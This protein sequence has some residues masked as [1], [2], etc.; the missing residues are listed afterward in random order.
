MGQIRVFLDGDRNDKYARA[1]AVVDLLVRETPGDPVD[2]ID[3]GLLPYTYTRRPREFSDLINTALA[4][5]ED[6]V[7][8]Q[9]VHTMAVA[10]IAS[11]RA[12]V[13]YAG[14][15]TVLTASTSVYAKYAAWSKATTTGCKQGIDE[16]G[17]AK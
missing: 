13:Q 6:E 9:F 5:Y 12:F 7:G 3:Q 8:D 11:Y 2:S 16:M 15:D 14:T 4:T 10:T 17:Q 1:R